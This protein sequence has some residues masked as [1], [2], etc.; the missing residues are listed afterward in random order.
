MNYKIGEKIIIEKDDDH[1]MLL[2]LLFSRYKQAAK[3]IETLLDRKTVN[4]LY[5]CKNELFGT[6]EKLYPRLSYLNYGIIAT[7]IVRI[8]KF[9][10]RVYS[11]PSSK[12]RVIIPCTIMV[13]VKIKIIFQFFTM[14][15]KAPI[16][17]KVNS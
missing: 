17:I 6:I 2:T 7:I 14:S 1:F 10:S 16:V 9:I 12:L 15:L 3:T 13:P 4:L 5:G 11:H 8:I